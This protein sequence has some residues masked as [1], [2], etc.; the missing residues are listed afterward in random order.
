MCIHRVQ[1][2]VLYDEVVYSYMYK[3]RI[4]T[5]LTYMYVYILY[6]EYSYPKFCIMIYYIIIMQAYMNIIMINIFTYV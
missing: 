3:Q 2:N 4:I 5:I 1:A 6:V